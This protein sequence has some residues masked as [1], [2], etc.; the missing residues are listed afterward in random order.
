MDDQLKLTCAGAKFTNSEI[1]PI[2]NLIG[3]HY[4]PIQ[5]YR[6]LYDCLSTFS[7]KDRNHI[8]YLLNKFELIMNA[9]FKLRLFDQY[10]PRIKPRIDNR[11]LSQVVEIWNADSAPIEK[12]IYWRAI[13]P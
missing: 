12:K 3:H 11:S 7:G 8:K 2:I 13:E 5:I 10:V 9:G 1:Q 6:I 4:A